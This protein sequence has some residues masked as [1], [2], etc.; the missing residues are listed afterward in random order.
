MSSDGY[1]FEY[2]RGLLGERFGAF[3]DAY[4]HKPRHKALRVNTLKISAERFIELSGSALISNPLCEQ[5]FYCEVKPSLD[6]LYHAGLYYMQEPS[7]SAAVAAFAPFIGERVLD[8]CAAPGGKATQAAQYMNGNGIIFCNDKEYKRV[9]AL[10][11]NIERL[12]VKNAVVT[13][14]TAADYRKAGFDGYFDTLIIDA[15]C[16]GGGMTRYEDVPYSAEVVAGC[17]ARQREI[18]RD[19]SELLASG[20]YMLYSTCTFAKEE[21]EDNVEFL[22]SLGMETADIP[23]LSGTERGIGERDA[24]RVYP[25]DFDGEGHFYCVLVKKGKSAECF[26]PTVRKKRV[27]LKL[28]GLKLEAAEINKRL[29][30]P[31]DAPETYGLNVMRL[32][33]P[34]FDADKEPSHALVHALSQEQLRMFGTVDITEDAA[35][36]IGGEQISRSAPKGLIA[37]TVSGYAVGLVRSAPSGDGNNA[38]KNKYPKYLR[39]PKR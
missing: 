35:A 38:L 18:L 27:D 7:A 2:M 29:V 30:L 24:R 19:S 32:S 37:A 6:P 28:N 3:I 15:P 5:S 31:I 12:G 22:R 17:A 25:M 20:G 21:N 23:L 13:C 26:K 8:L 1:F 16:S 14:N 34:V 10:T 11:E 9:K 39:V 4:E 36:Y 33:T